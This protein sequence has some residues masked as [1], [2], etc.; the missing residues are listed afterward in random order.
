MS[1]GDWLSLHLPFQPPLEPFLVNE[2]RRFVRKRVAESTFRGWFFVRQ[3]Q[4]NVHARLRFRLGVGVDPRQ[5]AALVEGELF[6]NAMPPNA[7][8]ASYDP[9]YQRYGGP[10]LMEVA[11]VQF[12]ASSEAVVEMI[13]GADRWDYQR[14]FAGALR[15]HF[16]LTI[17][18]LR[19]KQS[20]GDFW[21]NVERDWAH[22]GHAI[23]ARRGRDPEELEGHFERLW[24]A[25]GAML[26]REV[27]AIANPG[28]SKR[29]LPCL[30]RF[31]SAMT[32]VAHAYRDA[33]VDFEHAG[34]PG[35][36]HEILQSFAH[37]TN[38]RLGL[39]NGD[40]ACVAYLVRRAFHEDALSR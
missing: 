27:A 12:Q 14:A 2:I 9:E 17:T 29:H 30:D 35:P 32:D 11:E 37:M 15:M 40:E 16:I 31:G 23:L 8:W 21:S 5:A 38:N 4:P 19:T 1:Y 36:V 20:R 22:F 26:Q 18:C 33:G 25:Y 3:P 7:A 34:R 10:S 28:L 39:A 24:E 6:E 13:A